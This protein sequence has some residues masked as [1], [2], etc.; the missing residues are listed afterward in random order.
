MDRVARTTS[1]VSGPSGS[2]A[3][4][5]RRVE[6]ALRDVVLGVA[7]V[8]GVAVAL[9]FGMGLG[10]GVALVFGLGLGLG[11]GVGVEVTVGSEPS[12]VAGLSWGAVVDL[13]VVAAAPAAEQDAVPQT[14]RVMPLGRA[15]PA[16]Q[17][18]SWLGAADR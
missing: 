15:V 14:L 7:F 11:L 8:L 1:V 2:G 3:A 5:L 16:A 9:V 17:S 6:S 12:A 18:S 4:G 10:A 13:V